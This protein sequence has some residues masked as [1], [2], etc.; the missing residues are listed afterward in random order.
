MSATPS[1]F[2]AGI[3]TAVI[4]CRVSTV[5]QADDE[6]PI[7]SQRQRCEEKARAMGATVLRIYADEGISG[8]SDSRPAFQQAILYCETHAPT[9][10]ITWSTSRFA[11]N[12]LD[13][14]LYKRRL[15]KAG[16]SLIYAGMEI[17]RE[18]QGG[19]LQEGI[20]ELF[21]E[22]A[23][24]QVA[25]D[26]RRSMIKAAQSGYRCGGVSPFG[27]QAVPAPDDPK[28][29]RLAIQPAEA[30][31]VRRLF[32]MRAQG[33]GA[34]GIAITLNDEGHFNRRHRWNKTSILALLRNQAV[35]GHIVFGRV[36]K[37]NGTRY[38]AKPEDWIVVPAHP[39]IIERPLWDLV[40]QLLDRDAA[41]T[42]SERERGSPH[43]TYLFTGLLRCSRCGASL[44][45]ETAKGRNRRYAYYNC[46]TAQRRGD[47][48]TR[49]LPARD[50][51][52]WLF[53]VIC[54][55]V[56]TPNTL[57]AVV[58]ELRTLTGRWHHDRAERRRALDAQ[59]QT[60]ARRNGNL[61]EVLE[62]MGRDTPNLSDL[63]QR[64]RENNARLRDLEA[65]IERLD[66]EEPPRCEMAENDLADLAGYL[67]ALLRQEYNSRKT[68]ALFSDFIEKIM[69][70]RA[71]VA[72]E[73]N[74]DRM[75]RAIPAASCRPV[76]SQLNWLPDRPLL[77][78]QRLVRELPAR[79][80]ARA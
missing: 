27:Y 14:Q 31:I 48:Q 37:E 12:R 56:L 36:V 33:H 24:K 71:S 44:Q 28:R 58:A 67:V 3:R 15:G 5:R 60:I 16:V 47:C 70:E 78:T 74:P 63:T 29:R 66:A 45:I 18:S 39:P 42:H 10:F 80:V 7:Q 4:Y 76:P 9:F 2:A 69:I 55:D 65:Q 6:L 40:Q 32:E 26:T 72:I 53:E 62:E 49:R 21:D 1:D 52:A 61:Y 73:Y 8:Q 75:I 23:S 59:R 30:A 51:D 54:A 41:N 68:R 64:L 35:L 57:R 38:H 79:M 34:R 46:R 17:D 25:A 22:Y 50:L 11:R 43:S 13:A 20:M 19:W 77:G